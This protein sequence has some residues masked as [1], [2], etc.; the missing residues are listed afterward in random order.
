MAECFGSAHLNNLYTRLYI[1]TIDGSACQNISD[2][3]RRIVLVERM[4]ARELLEVAYLFAGAVKIGRLRDT[5]VHLDD[6]L[7][8]V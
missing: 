4:S 6:A 3:E 5:I 1:Y 8:V 7:E 2:V